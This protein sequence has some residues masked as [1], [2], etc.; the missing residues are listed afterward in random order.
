MIE[1][2]QFFRFLENGAIVFRCARNGAVPE[3]AHLTQYNE[4]IGLK[5]FFSKFLVFILIEPSDFDKMAEI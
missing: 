2:L 3:M 5:V 1:G 4:F